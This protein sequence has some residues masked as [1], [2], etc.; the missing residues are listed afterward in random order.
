MSTTT[1]TEPDML[2]DLL[3]QN[4]NIPGIFIYLYIYFSYV[5]P[6][7]PDLLPIFFFSLSLIFLPIYF[8]R[9]A[10]N[11]ST[12]YY[13]HLSVVNQF[14]G[15][16][17]CI[18]SYIGPPGPHQC[19]CSRAF[20]FINY[21]DEIA[22]SLRGVFQVGKKTLAIFFLVWLYTL[23]KFLHIGSWRS[24]MSHLLY[25]HFRGAFSSTLLDFTYKVFLRV[26]FY[27]FPAII[28]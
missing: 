9:S 11:P 26:F 10:L 27:F 24:V 3:K 18:I 28:C 2:F 23:M 15:A 25:S 7:P 13:P 6:D 12:F 20:F 16:T 4:K 1:V 22:S 19:D 14:W 17:V 8:C 21:L 5:C